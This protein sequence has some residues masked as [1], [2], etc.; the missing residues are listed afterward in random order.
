MAADL[1]RRHATHAPSHRATE[2]T[3]IGPLARREFW[4]HAP[5]GKLWAFELTGDEIVA[6][7]GPFTVRLSDAVNANELAYDA[8]AA[9]LD[10]ARQ[11]RGEFQPYRPVAGEPR[12]TPER[13]T[14]AASDELL[15]ALL[16]DARQNTHAEAGT[17]FV[18]E[19]TRLRF[20]A[21][22]NDVLETRLGLDTAKQQL[23][24]YG[25][26]L[27]ERSIASYV[28]LMHTPVNIPDAYAIAAGAPY[29][30]NPQ[31]DRRNDYRTRSILAMPLRDADGHVFG[32]LQLI[33]PPAGF[34]FDEELVRRA[35]RLLAD[36][37]PR[38]GRH[39]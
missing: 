34:A 20:A 7:A 19:G 35:G 18:R 5:S 33:N 30:F 15:A 28:L 31:W 29:A 12:T 3:R 26:P 1:R 22:Y 32:V 10:W 9:T 36:W 21:S 14:E 8:D 2:Q 13:S 23:T 39:R 17:V 27:N 38:L 25:L 11:H 6:H 4:L 16:A 24:S 37:A